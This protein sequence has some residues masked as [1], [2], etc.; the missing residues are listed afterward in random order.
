MMQVLKLPPPAALP[1][2]HRLLHAALMQ[3]SRAAAQLARRIEVAVPPPKREPVVEYESLVIDGVR[4]G[5]R[6]EDGRLV[7]LLPGV[8]RL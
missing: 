2:P 3:L 8:A 1:Q 5:A 7:A 4:Y 6:Y